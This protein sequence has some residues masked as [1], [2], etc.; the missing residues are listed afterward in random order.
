MRRIGRLAGYA[1]RGALAGLIAT[2]LMTLSSTIEMKLRGRDPSDTPAKAAGKVLGVQPRD[3]EGSARFGNAVHWSYGT[4]WGAV[5]GLL[6]G[7]GLREP[8][9]T[10]THFASV[11]G[12]ELVVLP[13]LGVSPPVTEWGAAEV[14]I[15]A[16]HHLIYALAMA[17]AWQLLRPPR[18]LAAITQGLTRS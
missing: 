7:F 8:L 16:T 12:A 11:W 2:S 6:R 13:L 3:P 5:G 18:G 17:G 14:G 15:D 10:G 9:A 1:G 4:L